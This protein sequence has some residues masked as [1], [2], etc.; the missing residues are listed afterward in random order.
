MMPR[1]IPIAG[2]RFLDAGSAEMMAV[3]R[4]VVKVA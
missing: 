4:D 1:R 2:V 3:L